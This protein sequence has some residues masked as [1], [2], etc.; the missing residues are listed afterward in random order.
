[1]RYHKIVG[2]KVPT[3]DVKH[4]LKLWAGTTIGG[5]PLITVS[6]VTPGVKPQLVMLQIHTYM[7]LSLLGVAVSMLRCNTWSLHTA[8]TFLMRLTMMQ[9]AQ[10]LPEEMGGRGWKGDEGR[11]HANIKP[12]SHPQHLAINNDISDSWPGVGG[13]K[14]CSINACVYTLWIYVF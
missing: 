13:W 9:G 1:M 5:T 2:W 12:C 11:R 14:N 4:C 7:C 6:L 10:W 8:Q 3:D